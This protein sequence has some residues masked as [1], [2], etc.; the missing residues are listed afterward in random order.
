M[1]MLSS[2]QAEHIGSMYNLQEI[3]LYKDDSESE[4][5]V[6]VI[7]IGQNPTTYDVNGR[8]CDHLWPYFSLKTNHIILGLGVGLTN[9]NPNPII[10]VPYCDV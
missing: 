3:Y 7:Y 2:L 9:P 5:Y 6:D 4:F 10:F 8:Q 1:D